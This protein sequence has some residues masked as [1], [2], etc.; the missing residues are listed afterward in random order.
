MS[1]LARLGAAAPDADHAPAFWRSVAARFKDVPGIAY[2]LFNEP[3]DI[4]WAC[5]RD[6]CTTPEGWQ[7]AGMQQ[8]IDAV[9]STGSIQPVIA[10]G[11]NWGGDLSGWLANRPADP[12]G[13]LAAGW[14]VYDFSGCN[15]TE[16]WDRTAAPVASQVPVVATEVGERDCAGGFMD[17][18]LAWADAHGIGYTAWAWNTAD[19]SSG[20]SLIS[21]YDRTPTGYGAAYKQHLAA[22]AAARA[23][24]V[25]PRRP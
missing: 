25:V 21:A 1:V 15:T 18:L 4:S 2:D 10:M 6:G 24:D 3:R 11:L 9:R 20:P 5:W 12:A 8:L 14:H 23:L 13:Q 7:A 17:A 19:C 22:G 16:C